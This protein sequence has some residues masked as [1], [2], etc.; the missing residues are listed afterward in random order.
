VGA[1]GG[2]KIETFSLAP[3]REFGQREVLRQLGRHRF[4]QDSVIELFIN[5]KRRIEDADIVPDMGTVYDV[6]G[7]LAPE[8]PVDDIQH[9]FKGPGGLQKC[10]LAFRGYEFQLQGLAAQPD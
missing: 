5:V 6:A 4:V 1:E 3:F 10:S 2:Q 9:F 8:A 7:Q